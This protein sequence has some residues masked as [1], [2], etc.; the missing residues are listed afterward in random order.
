MFSFIQQY[1]FVDRIV[2]TFRYRNFNRAESKTKH[3]RRSEK[4]SFILK[5][6]NSIDQIWS[7]NAESCGHLI[8]YLEFRGLMIHIDIL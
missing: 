7:T 8:T 6:E 1:Y 3:S 5:H 2:A 4:K